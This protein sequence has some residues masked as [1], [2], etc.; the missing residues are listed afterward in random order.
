MTYGYANEL[1]AVDCV[2][3]V[4]TL[5]GM[6]GMPLSEEELECW[7]DLYRAAKRGAAVFRVTGKE[8]G[9]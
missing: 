8:R 6:R 9:C 7:E 1:V 2:R 5:D 3:I 4:E